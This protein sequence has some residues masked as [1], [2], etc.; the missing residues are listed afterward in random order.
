MLLFKNKKSIFVRSQLTLQ[1]PDFINI[2]DK[3]IVDIIVFILRWL[4]FTFSTCGPIVKNWEKK[5]TQFMH[6]LQFFEY[7][8]VSRIRLSCRVSPVW[9]TFVAPTIYQSFKLFI[10]EKNLYMAEFVI[11]YDTLLS[12]L[13]YSEAGRTGIKCLV[14]WMDMFN[15]CQLLKHKLTA[16]TILFSIKREKKKEKLLT[17]TCPQNLPLASP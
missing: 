15:M 14:S 12:R 6:E 17:T 13:K 4:Y 11:C 16:T 7:A 1:K 2:S 5:K 3:K 9:R 8:L 10:N